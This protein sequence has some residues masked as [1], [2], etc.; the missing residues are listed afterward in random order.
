MTFNYFEI[1]LTLFCYHN[2]L[3]FHLGIVNFLNLSTHYLKYS[4]IMNQSENH[5]NILKHYLTLF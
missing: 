1:I 5:I 4:L 2:N 3:L